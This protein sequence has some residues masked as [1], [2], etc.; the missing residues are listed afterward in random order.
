MWEEQTIPNPAPANC[1]HL[2]PL[3]HPPITPSHDSQTG[4]AKGTHRGPAHLHW[5]RGKVQ[6]NSLPFT[7]PSTPLTSEQGTGTGCAAPPICGGGADGVAPFAPPFPRPP[8]AQR[9]G[10]TNEHARRPPHLRRGRG[11]VRLPSLPLPLL[12][13]H[14]RTNG[15]REWDMQHP[16]FAEGA[17]MGLPPSPLLSPGLHS[18]GEQDM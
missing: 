10:R 9:I 17:Q 1:P 6:P 8:L 4:H 7:P 3:S 16:P 13:P 14:S 11:K 12:R 2:S 15:V 5:G 18:H